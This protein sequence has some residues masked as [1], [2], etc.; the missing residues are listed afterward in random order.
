MPIVSEVWQDAGLFLQMIDTNIFDSVSDKNDDNDTKHE[1]NTGS[2]ITNF[3][4]CIQNDHS[5][6]STECLSME[7]ESHVETSID[8]VGLQVWRGALYLADYIIMHPSFFG[9]KIC[10]LGFVLDVVYS[11]VE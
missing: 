8:F 7:I 5:D 9:N 1:E 11:L 4:C 2:I 6:R 10:V 3:T